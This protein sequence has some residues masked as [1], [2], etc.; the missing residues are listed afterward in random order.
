M[1]TKR[2]IGLIVLGCLLASVGVLGLLI[3]WLGS[4]LGI[5]VGLLIAVAVIGTYLRVLGPWQ[6]R[7]GATDDEV[8]RAMPGDGLLRPDAPSTT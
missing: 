3:V 8:R 4:A 7:W 5:L 2:A 1:R 6:R